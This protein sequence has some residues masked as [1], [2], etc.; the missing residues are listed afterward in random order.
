MQTYRFHDPNNYNNYIPIKKQPRLK[1]CGTICIKYIFDV[2]HILIVRGKR[3]RIWSLPK[4]CI[5]EG[6][7]ENLCAQ[8][9]TLEESG[10]FVDLNEF[11][12][13]VC[14][15]HNVYFV[16]IIKDHP[17]LK[18]RDKDEVDKVNWMT[19]N[20]IR[21]LECNKDLRSI[22]QYPQRKFNFHMQLADVLKLDSLS[23]STPPNTLNNELSS[24]GDESKSSEESEETTNKPQNIS[25]SDVLFN[26]FKNCNISLDPPPGLFD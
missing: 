17:K 18:I 3:S 11:Q 7:S 21:Y 16:V 8:R 2:A 14:I 19:L 20:E 13:R 22:L 23:S 9:E 5:N 4:G 12:M 6:E 24:S 1:R 25:Y 10:L 15:N 26:Y